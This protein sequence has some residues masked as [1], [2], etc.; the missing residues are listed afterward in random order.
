MLWNGCGLIDFA[1][2]FSDEPVE[3]IHELTYN[4]ENGSIPYMKESV[5][6]DY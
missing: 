4:V 3:K 2:A 6:S 5:E 1:N